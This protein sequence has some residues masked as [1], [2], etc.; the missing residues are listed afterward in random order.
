[1][2]REELGEEEDQKKKKKERRVRGEEGGVA[3]EGGS[4]SVSRDFC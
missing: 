1:M 2:Q 3:R 4:R